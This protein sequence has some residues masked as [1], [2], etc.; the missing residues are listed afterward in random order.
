MVFIVYFLT[1]NNIT[2]KKWGALKNDTF[3]IIL[4]SANLFLFAKLITT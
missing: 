1:T 2:T 4:Q 3:M